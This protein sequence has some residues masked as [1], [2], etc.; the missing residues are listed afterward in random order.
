MEHSVGG[1][2][3]VCGYDQPQN[4]KS[5]STTFRRL[6][7]VSFASINRADIPDQSAEYPGSKTRGGS[8]P[9]SSP[10]VVEHPIPYD[11]EPG[12]DHVGEQAGTE[13]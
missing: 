13:E 1:K 7:G 3:V 10:D 8:L 9:L 12:D 5:P 4:A 2:Q 6:M 11:D